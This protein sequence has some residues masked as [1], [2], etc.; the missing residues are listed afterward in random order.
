MGFD[1]RHVSGTELLH[2]GSGGGR[3]TGHREIFIKWN[4]GI[5]GG[6]KRKPLA[7]AAALEV[8]SG[9]ELLKEVKEEGKAAEVV[10]SNPRWEAAQGFFGGRVKV[11]VEGEPPVAA[12]DITKVEFLVFPADRDGKGGSPSARGERGN[13]VARGVGHLKEG[14]AEAEIE[15]PE[16]PVEGNGNGSGIGN[17]TANGT[18]NGGKQPPKL[19]LVFTARHSRSK[20][21]LSGRLAIIEG[22][23][24]DGVI[25]YSPTR[26]E[27]L[28]LGKE[29]EARTWFRKIAD[30]EALR[31]AAEKAR[32]ESDPDA[33]ARLLD[34]VAERTGRMFDDK[35]IGRAPVID[36]LLLIKSKEGWGRCNTWTYLPRESRKEGESE[37]PWLKADD[38]SIKRPLQ[39]E[40]LKP[41]ESSPFLKGRFKYRLFKD[42]ALPSRT[43]WP[44]PWHGK[45]EA[46]KDDGCFSFAAEAAC[47]RFAMGWNGVDATF[48]KENGKLNLGAAGA[49]S[50]GL[51]E[52]TMK[53]AVS[54]PDRDGVD[55]LSF[56]RKSDSMNRAI[57]SNRE[58]RLRMRMTLNGSTFAGLTVSGALNFPNLDFRKK[59]ASLGGGAGGFFGIQAKGRIALGM[60]WSDSRVEANFRELGNIGAESGGSAGLGAEAKWKLAY[61]KGRFTFTASAALALGLGMRG[62]FSYEVDL[63]AGKEFASH[64]LHSVDYHHV[65]EITEEAYAA[66]TDYGFAK[67]VASGHWLD[68]KADQAMG[69]VADFDHW[70]LSNRG[71]IGIPKSRLT[72][73]AAQRSGLRYSTPEA[74]GQAIIAIMVTREEADFKSILWML[75]SA[76]SRH[77]L[78]WILRVV[79]RLPRKGT[80]VVEIKA[81]QAKA[82]KIGVAKIRAFGIGDGK[83]PNGPFL[84]EFH[85]LLASKGISI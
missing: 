6:G 39:K 19:E 23:E 1:S 49:V 67:M 73:A 29:A 81:K 4:H 14:K 79:S 2:Q 77:K 5:R 74:I 38:I 24:F 42:K 36:E 64:L 83:D 34:A 30:M 54:L 45:V 57:R 10:L 17:A 65:F 37:W 20:E 62:G 31:E 76:D 60:E 33:K 41:T 44:W 22:P 21:V 69:L 12:R 66:L 15:L 59:E 9:P 82:L 80:S 7:A 32:K 61:A 52:G 55:L 50:W 16:A 84:S 47:C 11:S 35:V 72:E 46:G 68:G 63:K 43:T 71:R 40:L 53:G 25:F 75:Y 26:G 70:L 3:K 27:Y 48:D 8:E 78:E 13:P 85:D 58:C 18:A 51:F 56:L 28:A